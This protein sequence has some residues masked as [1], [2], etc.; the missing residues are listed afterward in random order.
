MQAYITRMP[1]HVNWRITHRCN[2]GKC[3]F[4]YSPKFLTP[5][6]PRIA[7]DVCE[8]IV[9]NGVQAVVIS[10]GEPLTHPDLLKIIKTLHN[11]SISVNLSTNGRDLLSKFPEYYKYIDILALPIDGTQSVHDKIRGIGNYETILKILND[12]ADKNKQKK[13]NIKIKIET[14]ILPDNSDEYTLESIYNL[15]DTYAIDVWKLFEYNHYADRNK[16]I[17]EVDYQQVRKWVD[18]KS[19]GSGLTPIYYNQDDRSS[20]YFIIN[21]DARVVIP[22]IKNDSFE[23]VDL[24]SLLEAPKLTIEKWWSSVNLQKY[25]SHFEKM[26]NEIY[27]QY[28]QDDR[29]LIGTM[30]EA[31]LW[32]GVCKSGISRVYTGEGDFKAFRMVDGEIRES[33]FDFLKSAKNEVTIIS[34]GMSSNIERLTDFLE[35]KIGNNATFKFELILPQLGTETARVIS[36]S[37]IFENGYDYSLFAAQVNAAAEA[38]MAVK[39]KFNNTE[40][41][42]VRFTKEFIFGST[43]LIDGNLVQIESKYAGVSRIKNLVFEIRKPIHGES[44]FNAQIEGI[45]AIL[46]NSTEVKNEGSLGSD[47]RESEAQV[48]WEQKLEEIVLD[49]WVFPFVSLIAIL[50]FNLLWFI[51]TP[52]HFFD[53]SIGNIISI[54]GSIL[55]AIGLGKYL[56]MHRL[57]RSFKLIFLGKSLIISE[58]GKNA[59]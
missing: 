52:A 15:C 42:T 44:Y 17:N 48:T 9:R 3:G 10:G 8:M 51:N 55:A 31:M 33:L 23:D 46:S 21:P 5:P 36:K 53:L 13:S 41:I 38:V 14:V 35:E 25:N 56:K 47:L 57:K 6:N 22:E 4:C 11:N 34:Y 18:S 19:S 24:G 27:K 16:K 40:R 29:Y 54:P 30:D 49:A 58:R 12:V 20:R 43:I 32:R 26:Y 7:T 45:K 50:M 59:I 1:P 28:N 37:M 2:H 39:A